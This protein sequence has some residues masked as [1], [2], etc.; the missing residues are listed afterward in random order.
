[1]TCACMQGHS[2]DAAA[3]LGSGYDAADQAALCG[4]LPGAW[5]RHAPHRQPW[6]SAG[7]SAAIQLSR[8]PSASALLLSWHPCHRVT[9]VGA[10][11]VCTTAAVPTCLAA[12]LAVARQGGRYQW[13]QCL[14][15]RVAIKFF[16]DG[17]AFA[18]DPHTFSWMRSSQSVFQCPSSSGMRTAVQACQTVL[19]FPHTPL[20][21]G[22]SLLNAGC[23]PTLQMSSPPCRLPLSDPAPI[24]TLSL[25]IATVS[26]SSEDTA[27]H[28]HA[29]ATCL[30]CALLLLLVLKPWQVL[31]LVVMWVRQC[32]VM[33]LM[34]MIQGVIDCIN[35]HHSQPEL[36]R[37][38]CSC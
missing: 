22:Q 20:L 26:T 37:C 27:S 4:P 8:A 11:H 2:G 5:P 30:A 17:Q 28:A 7:R 13:R 23:P 36:T 10:H 1:M 34:A 35:S 29:A 32:H 16:I 25:Q 24:S 12:R 18:M 33:S 21:T 19:C 31:P 14:Q 6:S 3:V 38:A 9:T 15:D